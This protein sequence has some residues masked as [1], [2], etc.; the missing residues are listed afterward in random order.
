MQTLA[1]REIIEPQGYYLKDVYLTKA[2]RAKAES[3]YNYA[4]CG[5]W[6]SDHLGKYPSEFDPNDT[7]EET[8]YVKAPGTLESLISDIES[9]ATQG[10]EHPILEMEG[11]SDDLIEGVD[12][13]IEFISI[14][15]FDLQLLA[16][17]LNELHEIMEQ[18]LNRLGA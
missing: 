9:Q 10:F 16:K 12:Y 18:E 13:V 4:Y 11:Y 3:L 2:G 17:R 5:G 7:F 15:E 6:A 1:P 8:Y 14:E